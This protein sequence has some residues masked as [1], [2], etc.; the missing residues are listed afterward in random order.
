M[1]TLITR[2][3]ARGRHLSSVAHDLSGSAAA[4]AIVHGREPTRGQERPGRAAEHVAAAAGVRVAWVLP[5][6]AQLML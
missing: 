5:L 3:P 2:T 4:R 6:E 1:P